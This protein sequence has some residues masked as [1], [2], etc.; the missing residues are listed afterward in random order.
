MR[1]ERLTL[2]AF[3][4]Y[5]GRTELDF[6]QLG[7][8]GLYLICGDTG[9]GKTTL[10]D[11]LSFALYGEPSGEARTAQN[12]YSDFALEG[13]KPFVELEF[14]YQGE[15][16]RIRRTPAYPYRKRTGA[17]G[18]KSPTVEFE[19]PDKDP[20][21]R[22]R[23][24]NEAVVELL[25]LDRRQFSQIVMIAQGEFRKLLHATTK[26]RAGIFRKLFD[27]GAYDS[28]QRDLQTQ[29]SQAET[30]WRDIGRRLQL[31]AE[32][33]LFEDGSER[34]RE[35]E[36]NLE[37]GTLLAETLE[38]ALQA[39]I[40]EDE[41]LAS[42]CAST[43]ERYRRERDA[44]LQALDRAKQAQLATV[45]L[46]Q[47]ERQTAEEQRAQT[48]A[49]ERLQRE[50]GRENERDALR[51]RI[52]R[53]E[54]ALPQFD[55]SDEAE[56]ALVAAQAVCSRAEEGLA[57]LRAGLA[58]AQE[59]LAVSTE[60][61]ARL[62][63]APTR[64]VE[65]RHAEQNA[66]SELEAAR[67]RT[68]HHERY[69]RALEERRRLEGTAEAAARELDEALQNAAEV[70]AR[71]EDREAF[72]AS[73][74]DAPVRLER[75]QSEAHEAHGA[76]ARL[77]RQR[78][79]I[80]VLEAQLT[81]A[82]DDV[83][84]AQDSYREA[85]RTAQR[86]E[87][88][89]QESRQRYLDAQ[90]GLLAQGLTPTLPCPVC[91]STEHPAPAPVPENS[92]TKEEVDALGKQAEHDRSVQAERARAASSA[93]ATGQERQRA[94]EKACAEHGDAQE[95]ARKS[96][97]EQAKAQEA[98]ARASA[99]F[100]QVDELRHAQSEFQQARDDLARIDA[101]TDA[102]RQRVSAAQAEAN[103]AQA[104]CAEL[105]LHLSHPDLT[106]A[107]E[108]Q[109]HAEE[110][111][112]ATERERAVAEADEQRLNAARAALQEE[113]RALAD[114]QANEARGI[115]EL[116]RAQA[117]LASATAT[118]DAVR[119]ALPFPTRTEALEGIAGL[120]TELELITRA[121]E[122]AL[123]DVQARDKAFEGSRARIEALKEQARAAD[124]S[125][126]A[127]HEERLAALDRNIAAVEERR[128]SIDARIVAN[129][130]TLSSVERDGERAD[131]LGRR[132][133]SLRE[134]SDVATGRL[135]GSARISF[136]TYVQSLYFDLV[137]EAANLRYALV[138]NDRYQLVRRKD[139]AGK[140]RQSGL[141]LDVHDCFTGKT[142]DASTL[143]GGESFE[144]AL[145]LAL[146]L[147]D[148]V[149]QRAGGIRLDAMF[150]D[151]GFGSLDPESLSRAL[152]MLI[153][154]SEDDKLIGIISHV[155]ELKGSI[156]RKI[157]VTRTAEGSSHAKIEA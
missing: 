40:A 72:T 11:A 44:A 7:T 28:F 39:Q 5:A 69:D 95:L 56:N 147:S 96:E 103:A 93:Q 145:S 143:S 67:E 111:L 81:Q 152:A 130:S 47:A 154:I 12:L 31:A 22:E 8:A 2:Q 91:G 140:G 100:A 29:S 76:H 77:E 98:D 43:L 27:T 132:Y 127:E 142:R 114:T 88:A 36:R 120:K 10:F 66:Q 144:A 64:L 16:Y 133:R 79:Q 38:E 97:A 37:A 99:L 134:L 121:H 51:V 18:L 13:E 26:E 65:A 135:A 48:E 34:G 149:Q 1:P 156:D 46:E 6:S 125:K 126:R 155:E 71:I 75:A 60:T 90:A 104:R 84:R 82:L 109:A 45:Q 32:S 68:A 94:L 33:A 124:V 113:E 102:A 50:A 108:A 78:E 136:E 62:G 53:E 157:V 138:S 74:A 110:R 55:R 70:R 150:I 141:D 146:G 80:T 35:V 63:E 148:V 19:R 101:R 117:N 92:P 128:S 151:E 115:E 86:S 129:R 15:R 122:Q 14:S 58:G 123:A 105:A 118:R 57:A 52:A 116:A 30:A 61:I 112:E 131:E 73:L 17:I 42:T 85:T 87:A 41:S 20:L 153:G 83:K 59:R 3:G 107:R 54:S 9:S 21:T 137:I 106:A 49:R 25:G 119:S 24:A 139:A 89:L 4:P 23:D